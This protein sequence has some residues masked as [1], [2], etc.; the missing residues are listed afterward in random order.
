MR[1]VLPTLQE[2]DNFR[3][4]L[5]KSP[6]YL[7]YKA[8]QLRQ[9]TLAQG[10]TSYN[11]ANVATGILPK[12]V[13]FAMIDHRAMPHESKYNP[14]NFQHFGLTSYNLKKNGQNVFPKALE[15]NFEDGNYI[16]LYRHVFDNLGS[17]HG[18]YSCG[19][20]V[21]DFKQGRT[22]LVA[23][24]NPDQ[25]NSYHI[26]PD[27]YGNLD[28]ELSFAKPLEH[29]VYVFAFMIYNSGIKID[30]NLQVLKGNE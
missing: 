12:T 13:I 17:K 4:R 29:I 7:P 1:K 20:T 6:C 16:N 24:L 10:A 8:S 11:I 21:E 27:N 28:L 14:F 5:M 23:D 19:L 26:H 9:H 3:A 2:R 18:N 30:Q 25:C 22:F 15:S